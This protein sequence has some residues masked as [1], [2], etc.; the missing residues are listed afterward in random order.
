LYR[1]E[2]ITLESSPNS[3][4][5][6]TLKVL[7]MLVRL[8]LHV[9]RSN[10]PTFLLPLQYGVLKFA[11]KET[12]DVK[13]AIL[14]FLEQSDKRATMKAYFRYDYGD[15]GEIKVSDND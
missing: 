7:Y 13:K 4:W 3:L 14:T 2:E 9:C 6:P 15:T 5:E 12:K 10:T 8:N 11:E 1:E